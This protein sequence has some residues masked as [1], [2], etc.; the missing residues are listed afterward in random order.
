MGGTYG[1]SKEM[2]NE[3]K[4][5]VEKEEGK[6]KHKRGGSYYMDKKRS[7]TGGRELN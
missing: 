3:Y 5:F 6:T 7:K 2:R 1:L 4:V